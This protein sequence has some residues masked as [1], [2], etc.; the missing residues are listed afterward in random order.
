MGAVRGSWEQYISF[1][2]FSAIL[3]FVSTSIDSNTVVARV[4]YKLEG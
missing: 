4:W 3:K 1:S 2:S